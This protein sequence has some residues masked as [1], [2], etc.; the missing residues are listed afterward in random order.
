VQETQDLS[1]LARLRG[2]F[3]GFGEERETRMTDPRRYGVIEVCRI[4]AETYHLM[5]GGQ[6]WSEVE[7]SS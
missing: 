2:L 4:N 3:R 6:M 5:I 7:W 1:A